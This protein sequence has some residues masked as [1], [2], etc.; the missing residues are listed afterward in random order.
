MPYVNYI[1]E[2]VAF[3]EYA[4]DNG[5]SGNERLLWYAL[6]HIMNQRAQGANYPDGFI[7]IANKRLLSYAPMQFDAMAKARNALQQRGLI[8][9]THGKRNA[10][11]P[12]YKMNYFSCPADNPQDTPAPVDNSVLS[13][14]GY[15]LKTDNI[16][17][18]IRGN[19]QSNTQGNAPGS[20]SGNMGDIHN[21]LNVHH[22]PDRNPY[23]F[24]N[25]NDVDG[26]V[27]RAR[28]R[29]HEER[30][31]YAETDQSAL[32]HNASVTVDRV[33]RSCF[34]RQPTK[35]FVE[36]LGAVAAQL[37]M[38]PQMVEIAL[39]E[40]AIKNA[41][42]IFAYVVTLFRDWRYQEVTTPDEYGEYSFMRD[43][44]RGKITGVA[45]TDFVAMDDKREERKRK[46]EAARGGGGNGC[47]SE[48]DI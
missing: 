46:H 4:S 29:V 24:E 32:A 43:D 9:F 1:R 34:G 48:E 14:T 17:G 31:E 5:L 6:M 38:S 25:D 11:M 23:V 37:G 42:D 28:A 36:R 22:N 30:R 47:D 2:H 33:F 44:S 19:V 45:N 8:E 27:M 39:K 7:R 26:E 10:E 41:S 3:I 15:P 20:M 40:A 16:G 21:R 13:S 12:M 18:N 35:A